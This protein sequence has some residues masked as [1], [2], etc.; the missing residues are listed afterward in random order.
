MHGPI[1][2]IAVSRLESDVDQ[3]C[4]AMLGSPLGPMQGRSELGVLTSSI[5]RFHLRECSRSDR[6]GESLN[7][8]RMFDVQALPAGVG[9]RADISL[10]P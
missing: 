6:N 9:Y 4:G 1:E 10:M 3:Y 7:H 2:Q 5:E 8:A